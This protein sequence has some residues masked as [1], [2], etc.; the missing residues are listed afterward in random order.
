MLLLS[1]LNRNRVRV[2]Q[3]S[4]GQIFHCALGRSS[5]GRLPSRPSHQTV[6]KPTP[7]AKCQHSRPPDLPR[8]TSLRLADQ[9]LTLNCLKY[10]VAAPNYTVKGA[11][12]CFSPDQTSLATVP[13]PVPAS[14]QHSQPDA[15]LPTI[16]TSPSACF[17][18]LLPFFRLLNSG[19]Q[20]GFG[21]SQ[22]TTKRKTKPTDL[23]PFPRSPGATTTC[24]LPTSPAPFSHHPFLSSHPHHKRPPPIRKKH[25]PKKTGTMSN[26]EGHTSPERNEAPAGSEHLNLKVTDNN[27]EV[28]FK[29]KRSTKLEKLMNAFCERQGKSPS[30]VRFLF[31]GSRCQPTDTPDTVRFSPRCASRLSSFDRQPSFWFQLPR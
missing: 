2:D 12:T 21:T 25:R 5:R 26:E 14:P 23:Q 27:N 24:L 7:A 4:G 1:S 28:F 30:S 8:A 11:S 3:K 10:G 9:C 13:F 15:L 17:Q 31:E 16:P 22:A 19:A 29:I 18:G 20:A 6:C